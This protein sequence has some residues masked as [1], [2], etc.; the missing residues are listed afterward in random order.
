MD[1]I[2]GFKVISP[3][4]LALLR[5]GLPSPFGDLDKLASAQT[6][7]LG[8]FNVLAASLRPFNIPTTTFIGLGA[9]PRVY[10]NIYR[11]DNHITCYNFC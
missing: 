11:S 9:L 4:L 3:N 8:P 7:P 5:L 6:L 10:S 2:V 1:A